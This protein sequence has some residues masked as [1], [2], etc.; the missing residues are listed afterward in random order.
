MNLK[1][2][3]LAAVITLTLIGCGSSGGKKND[4]IEPPPPVVVELDEQLTLDT[5]VK[6]IDLDTSHLFYVDVPENAPA[7]VVT[8][9]SGSAG[10]NLGD[11]DLYVKFEEDATAGENGNFDCVSYNSKDYNE[12]CIISQP[13]AGRYSIL[14]DIANVPMRDGTL[15]ASTSLFNNVKACNE[16]VIV[17]AQNMSDAQIDSTCNTLDQTKLFFDTVLNEGVAPSFGEAVPNDR[18]DVTQMNIFANLANYKAWM[19]HLFHSNNESGIYFEFNPTQWYHQSIVNT[20]DSLEWNNNHHHIRSL[21][22]EYVHALDGRY[23][24]QG[25]YRPEMGWWSEGL[26]EYIGSFY[27]LPYE[28]FEI[29]REENHPTLKQI[30]NQHNTNGVPSP[31]DWGQLAV[32]YLIEKEPATVTEMLTMMR[33]G[34]WQAFETKLTEIAEASQTDFENYVKFETKEQ[35]I[36]SAK[37][38]QINSYEK[39]RG[40]GGGWLF[41]FTL[42]NPAESLT[43]KTQR[44]SGDVDMLVQRGSVPHWSF[45]EGEQGDCIAYTSGHEQCVIENAEAGEYFVLIDAHKWDWAEDIVDVYLTVCTGSE[46]SVELPDEAEKM[47]APA[48]KLP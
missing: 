13:A 24:K 30:F 14:V 18:N 48:V 26:A 28:R 33:S 43:V 16:P 20:F 47:T 36:N 9:S 10:K 2:T 15:W 39:I 32:A 19:K 38:M 45:D 6:N 44:G 31:Y 11:P 7:L 46:C 37:P 5:A 27:Q 4:P 1:R 17:R 12:Y 25:G 21:A 42:D 3:T 8:V 35:Y 22:H 23:N 34:D 40:I 29:S 41:K